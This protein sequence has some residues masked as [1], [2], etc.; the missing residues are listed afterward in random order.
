VSRWEYFGAAQPDQAVKMLLGALGVG[1]VLFWITQGYLAARLK[2]EVSGEVHPAA[3]QDQRVVLASVRIAN[4][5]SSNA[6]IERATLHVAAGASDA[7]CGGDM[8]IDQLQLTPGDKESKYVRIGLDSPYYTVVWGTEE[9]RQVA[10]VCAAADFY[11]LTL[12][13]RV[14]QA[15]LDTPQTW[16]ASA[17]V[18]ARE[19]LGRSPSWPAAE[20]KSA[21]LTESVKKAITGESK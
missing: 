16:R 8:G 4:V 21:G 12:E 1:V 5:G 19:A 10:R 9:M 6:S 2:V 18:P 17:I 15:L 20:P 13:V 3:A 11:Q 7:R 14:R